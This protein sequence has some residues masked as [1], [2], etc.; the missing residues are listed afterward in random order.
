MK[1]TRESTGN[2][3][4]AGGRY[5]LAMGL[6]PLDKQEW[7]APDAMLGEKLAEKRDLLATRHGEVLRALPEADSASLEL[8]QLLA[9]HLPHCYPAA[10]QRIGGRL[11]NRATDEVWDIAAPPL[12]PLD[13]AGRLVEEDLCLMHADDQGY[14]LVGASLCAPNR[15]HLDEKLGRPLAEIHA[16]VPNYAP[17]LDRPVAHFF[18]AL[19][20]GRILGRVNWGIADDPA[21]FQPEGRAVD[22]GIDAASAGRA[23]WL[24]L[25]RQSLRRLPETGAVLFAIRTE[26]TRL[27]CVIRSRAD[28]ADLAGAIR[29]MSP[30]MR[31][32]KHLATVAPALLAWLDARSHSADIEREI[33]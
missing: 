11:V 25:E 10:Y 3:L 1:A 26:I 12:H 15:W 5:R 30:A 16:P 22:S 8:L 13:L 28:A 32:Y 9:A 4:F 21:R 19:K 14:R 33:V 20:P 29:D 23:L 18:A 27:D 17:T 7:L 6:A 24:R 2:T 31:R